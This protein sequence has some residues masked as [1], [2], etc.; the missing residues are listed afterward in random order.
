VTRNI[1]AVDLGAESGRVMLARFDGERL[2]L[3][4][5][6]R[7][8]NRPVLLHR[9]LFW[10]M[11]A[12]WDET[13]VGLRKARQIAG[14][15]DSIGVDSWAVDYA[16]IDRAGYPIGY[17]Y[18]YRDHR[19]DGMME[20]VFAQIPYETLYQ[21]TGIQMLPIN[22]I[23][24]L[25]AHIQAQ[26]ELFMQAH[27][28]LM[29]PDLLHNWL[30]GSDTGERTNATTTQCW[31]PHTQSWATDI[32]DSLG[33]PATI[34]PPIVEAGTV[35]GP[36]LPELRAALG[37]VRVI[38]PA[39]HDT[40][41]AIASVPVMHTKSWAY[42]SSGTWSLI[43][44]ERQ[45]P[46]ITAEAQIANYTNEGGVFGTTRL[47]KNVMGLWLLQACQKVWSAQGY[48]R[49]YDTL[50][51]EADDSPAFA[52]MIDPDNARFLAPEDMPTT[53]NAYLI[54]RGQVA[55]STPASFAR[56]IMESLVLRYCIEIEHLQQLTSQEI[57]VI[58]IVGGGAR[59][60]LIN[61]WLADASGIVVIAGP[62]EATAIGNVLMQ[63]VGLGELHTLTDI[64]ALAVHQHTK[65]YVPDTRKRQPWDEQKTR[66]LAL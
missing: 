29:I 62:A 37:D 23:F 36:I 19:T 58:H 35:L 39:T 44:V 26:P 31:D 61:Q 2:H 22:T 27:R 15:L 34:F 54:E 48:Q 51:A 25:Y 28:L 38:T 6:H 63:L 9:H 57:E 46:L 45:R 16:L 14:T 3:E 17:P 10:N 24:Q 59:N 66:F 20:Q 32:L 52:T 64:R 7:F 18:H 47:L 8:T 4:E 65:T 49:S 30:C 41:S 5:V 50:L 60:Y 53:I 11:L 40:G 13:L 43:G 21:R 12:L 56:C 1:A 42:I 55:L 33:I